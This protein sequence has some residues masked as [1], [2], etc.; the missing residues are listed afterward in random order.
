MITFLVDEYHYVYFFKYLGGGV[1]F[2]F[3]KFEG[4]GHNSFT[5]TSREIRASLIQ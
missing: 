3:C 5:V 2:F 1:N 4:R